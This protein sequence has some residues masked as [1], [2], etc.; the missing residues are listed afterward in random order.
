VNSAQNGQADGNL[1]ATSFSGSTEFHN[2][3]FEGALRATPEPVSSILIG[4]G[5]IGVSLLARR[6]SKRSG[7][8]GSGSV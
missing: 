2:F 5:L 1:V 4:A 3:G 6:Q 8:L 7:K